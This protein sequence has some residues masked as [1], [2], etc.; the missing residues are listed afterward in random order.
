VA[1]DGQQTLI[2]RGAYRLDDNQTGR[3]TFQLHGNGWRFDAGHVPKLELLGAD[4]PY[5]RP[6]NGAFQVTVK[7]AVIELPTLEKPQTS[8]NFS[9][10]TAG[11]Q[12]VQPVLGAGGQVNPAAAPKPRLRISYSPHR[13][14]V[15]RR[16]RYLFRVR[17]RSV[18]TGKFRYIA[19]ARLVFAGKRFRTDSRGRLRTHHRFKRAGKRR[20]RATKAGY[21]SRNV[22][23][24]VLR[25]VRRR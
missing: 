25:P 16:S 3:V 8:A 23:V 17:A 20:V 10:T 22:Y 1:P 18:A 4:A 14:R 15:A 5:L 7:D 24:R 21:V 6:S 9:G 12:I 11:T 13:T 19:G 2:S